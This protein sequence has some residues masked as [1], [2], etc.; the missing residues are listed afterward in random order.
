M[1]MDVVIN[2]GGG[3]GDGCG[4][5]WWWMVVVD[6]HRVHLRCIVYVPVGDF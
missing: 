6:G 4:D 3:C 5:K 2:G 1:V